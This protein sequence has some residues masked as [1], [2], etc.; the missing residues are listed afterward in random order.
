MCIGLSKNVIR[1]LC[2]AVLAL[3]MAGCSEERTLNDLAQFVETTHRDTVPKVDPLPEQTPVIS[4]VYRADQ[5]QDPFARSNVFGT[6]E[7]EAVPEPEPDPLEPDAD[8]VPDPLEKFPLDALQML[9]TMRLEGSTWALVSAP[10]GE[11]HRVVVGTFLGQN[12]GKIVAITESD[13]VL[14]IEERFRGISGQWEIRPSQ[15]RAGR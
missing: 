3:T 12:N 15:M 8:R 6:P 11:I 7:A 10:D 14:E 2:S 1:T 5:S 13:G 4:I 9:G